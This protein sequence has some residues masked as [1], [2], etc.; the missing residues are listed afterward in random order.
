[1]KIFEHDQYLS[2]AIIGGL[3]NPIH[4][5]MLEVVKPPHTMTLQYGDSPHPY[6]WTQPLRGTRQ[7]TQVYAV[8]LLLQHYRVLQCYSAVTDKIIVVWPNGAH[9]K[10]AVHPMGDN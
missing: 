10:L 4:I 5:W 8:T 2:G 1:M 6:I 3:I 7:S 9:I